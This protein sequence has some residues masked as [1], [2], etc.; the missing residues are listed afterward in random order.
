M[1]SEELLLAV[2][3]VV[4]TLAGTALGWGLTEITKS[5][6]EKKANLN[7]GRAIVNELSD[8]VSNVEAGIRGIKKECEI[9]AGK[10]QAKYRNRPTPLDIPISTLYF[11]QIVYSLTDIERKN[12]K[13]VFDFLYNVN[14]TIANL[15]HGDHG[16]L[17]W[18]EKL[19]LRILVYMHLA[20]F[21]TLI[22]EVLENLNKKVISFE[23]SRIK[24]T[25]QEVESFQTYL[26][27]PN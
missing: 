21:K 13:S 23:D 17:N 20:V 1:L 27:N 2:V 18:N 14:E 3:G 10:K 12:L 9:F 8:L 6:E 5:R 11:P 4:G 16:Y 19:D 22:E 24:A 26:L 25:K 7:K 15:T